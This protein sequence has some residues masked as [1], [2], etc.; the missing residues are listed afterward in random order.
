MLSA[1]PKAD[2][3]GGG[4]AGTGGAAGDGATSVVVHAESATEAAPKADAPRNTRRFRRSRNS[5][6]SDMIPQ[7][8]IRSNE[9]VPTHPGSISHSGS[10]ENMTEPGHVR[11]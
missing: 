11:A 2:S 9:C 1:A 4:G 8:S 7:L 3:L 5:G 10:F 6:L